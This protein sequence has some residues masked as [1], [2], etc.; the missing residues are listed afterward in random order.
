MPISTQIVIFFFLSPSFLFYILAGK[1]KKKEE[2]NDDGLDQ[3][4][5]DYSRENV[6]LDFV[7]SP[8][9][10]QGQYLEKHKK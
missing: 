5:D 8:S 10:T 4:F 2:K 9:I 7:R 6:C 1:E 3:T